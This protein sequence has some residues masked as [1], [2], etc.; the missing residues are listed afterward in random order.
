M[1]RP[2]KVLAFFTITAIGAAIS[3]VLIPGS[4]SAQEVGRVSQANL[5]RAKSQPTGMTDTQ[6]KALKSLNMKIVIP[7]DVPKGFRVVGVT[8]E[9]C[10]PNGCRVGRPNYSILYRDPSKACFTIEGTSGGVGG[11]ALEP[12]ISVTS[13]LFGSTAVGSYSESRHVSS[14]WLSLSPSSGP[15]YRVYSGGIT[16][17]CATI[18]TTEEASQIVQSLKWMP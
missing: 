10:G 8:T 4:A 14:E 6:Y 16:R 5:S 13:K 7:A 1:I 11:P 15:F 9:A 3:G 17:G 18:I 2:F 12:E